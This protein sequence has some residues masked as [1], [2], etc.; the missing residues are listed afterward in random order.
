[1]HSDRVNNRRSRKAFTLIELLV[2]IAIIAL[3]MAIL[4]PALQR[5]RKQAQTVMCQSHLHQWGLILSMIAD[6]N[7]G[8]LK[9]TV[10]DGNWM[11][12]SR[13]YL[14]M[15]PEIVGK[16]ESPDI[17][18]CPSATKIDAA[19]GGTGSNPFSGWRYN[20]N[21][22]IYYGS[23]GINAWVYD[24]GSDGNYQD[25]PGAGMWRTTT[26]GGANNI[27]VFGP[28]FHGGGCPEPRDEPPEFSG[29]SWPSGH[30]NEMRRFCLNRH[31]GFVNFVFMDWS[32]RKVGL[33]ELWTLKWSR[34]F[35]TAGPWTKAG[36]ATGDV[37]RSY[38][39][40]W[41]APFKEY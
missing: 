26:V 29:Q 17:F 30:N 25:R 18:F 8:K 10:R 31:D 4:M 32:S 33:K 9:T 36:G 37:W 24:H 19:Y 7:N 38:G 1:M 35:D 2:V 21:D 34:T 39:S 5:V 27:P 11:V 16:E 13:P 15:G 22:V 6:D 28:C 41:L 20:N 12:L 14:E 40:G 3:L 23:Y